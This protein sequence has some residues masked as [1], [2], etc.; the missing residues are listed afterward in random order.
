MTTRLP[1][2]NTN[3]VRDVIHTKHQNPEMKFLLPLMEWR[4]S[5]HATTLRLRTLRCSSFCNLSR[6]TCIIVVQV[7]K[8]GGFK[9]NTNVLP[10]FVVYIPCVVQKSP[11]CYYSWWLRVGE[12]TTWDDGKLSTSCWC[13][14]PDQPEGIFRDI[15][16][17]ETSRSYHS[18]LKVD[19]EDW[20][21]APSFK[22][23]M[24]YF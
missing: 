9:G 24:I 14:Q 19:H 15:P 18:T 6:A 2:H 5:S 17:D 16:D 21:R 1:E 20:L 7:Q 12:I 3:Q 8:L 10:I 23:V 22:I 4:F 11:I 13:D